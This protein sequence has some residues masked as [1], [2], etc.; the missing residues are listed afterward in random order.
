M[1]FGYTVPLIFTLL[2][3]ICTIKYIRDGD[4]LS[5]WTLKIQ[6]CTNTYGSET[7]MKAIYIILEY[8]AYCVFAVHF[9]RGIFAVHMSIANITNGD[10][11]LAITLIE[12]RTKCLLFDI[13]VMYM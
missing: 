13:W 11:T 3:I 2:T 8:C 9:I 12:S 6:C 10:P 5:I 7:V 1:V 4:T